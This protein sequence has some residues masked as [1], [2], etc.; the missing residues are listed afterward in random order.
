MKWY[1]LALNPQS[2]AT[3][4]K[5]VP[6]LECIELFSL[7]LNRE[8]STIQIFADLPNFPDY[9]SARWNEK[10]NAVQIQLA[11]WGVTNF[12]AKGWQTNM[13]VKIDIIKEEEKLKVIISNSEI[14]L[15]FSF[16]CD[17]LR[18]E[19]ISAYQESKEL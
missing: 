14:N 3:L 2:L 8:G 10:F 17:F 5:T 6:E 4:Y 19:H 12:E 11:F 13:K 15:K 16:L 18:I 9:P 1:E 7:N